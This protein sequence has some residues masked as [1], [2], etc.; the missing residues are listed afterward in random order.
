[1]SVSVTANSRLRFAALVS[2][3]GIEFWDLLDLPEIVVQAGDLQYTVV[4]SD[5]IDLIA[6][7]FYG[8]PVLWWVIAAAN[9]M[10]LVPNELHSGQTLRIP[11]PSYVVQQLFKKSKAR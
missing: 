5:R 6:Q 1:V 10:E 3:D 7:K 8:D 2:S 11:S 4:E 9:G